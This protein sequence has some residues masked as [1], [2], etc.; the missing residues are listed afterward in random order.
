VLDWIPTAG[1]NEF[2]LFVAGRRMRKTEL[3]VFD[4][5][6]AIDSPQG[7]ITL[8]AEFTVELTYN[9]NGSVALAEIVLTSPTSEGNR[10]TIVRKQGKLWTDPGTPLKDMQNDIGNFLRQSVSELP[11]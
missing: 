4:P 2:E 7:D 9:E 1:V 11:E 8:P 10:I 3:E 6:L 5:T